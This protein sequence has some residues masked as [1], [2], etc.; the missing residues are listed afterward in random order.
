MKNR[1]LNLT[2]IDRIAK[3]NDTTAYSVN[4]VFWLIGSENFYLS[5]LKIGIQK[6]T[7]I[8]KIKKHY[9]QRNLYKN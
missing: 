2:V 3:A 7:F 9:P 6:T 4:K 5:E 8:E 1:Q